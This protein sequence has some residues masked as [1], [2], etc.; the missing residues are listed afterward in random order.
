M[1]AFLCYSRMI[2]L[3]WFCY[4]TSKNNAACDFDEIFY[5]KKGWGWLKTLSVHLTSHYI[6]ESDANS[7]QPIK[8]YVYDLIYIYVIDSFQPIESSNN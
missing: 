5:K 7:I 4:C 3:G 8:W 6:L 1:A 2:V